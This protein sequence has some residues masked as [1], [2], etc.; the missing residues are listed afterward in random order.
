MIVMM[1]ALVVLVPTFAYAPLRQRMAWGKAAAS[2]TS[3]Y[4][5]YQQQGTANLKDGAP[6]KPA[7]QSAPQPIRARPGGTTKNNRPSH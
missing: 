4:K 6:I 7:P 1:L 2:W 5:S 3:I